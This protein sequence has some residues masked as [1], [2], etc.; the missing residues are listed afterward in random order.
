[1]YVFYDC[2]ETTLYYDKDDDNNKNNDDTLH[3][4]LFVYDYKKNGEAV[5]ITPP[6]GL[7][8]IFNVHYH[9][10]SR[11]VDDF[12]SSGSKLKLDYQG[13]PTLA[14]DGFKILITTFRGKYFPWQLLSLGESPCY[15]RTREWGPQG[16]WG[17]GEKGYL[18]SGSWGAV[19]IILGELGSKHIL[20]GI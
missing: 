10:R 5:L 16:F 1:M 2:S 9:G 7:Y 15:V 18:F 19:L 13:H 14:Y 17:S 3:F 6:Q 20:L 8:G 11:G 12:L 4:R